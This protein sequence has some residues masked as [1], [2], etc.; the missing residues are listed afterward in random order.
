MKQVLRFLKLDVITVKPYLTWKNLLILLLMPIF[1]VSF[2]DGG[3]SVMFLLMGFGA[4]FASY[5]FAVGEQN[6]I[7]A[8]YATL[9]IKRESVVLGRYLFA[10]SA[11]LFVGLVATAIAAL[12]GIFKEA[13]VDWAQHSADLYIGLAFI[14]FVQAIQLPLFFHLGYAKAKMLGVL[15]FLIIPVVIL[16]YNLFREKLDTFFSS[17]HAWSSVN[18]MLT[19]V[20][21]VAAWLAAMYLSYRISSKAYNKREF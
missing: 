2:T 12:A 7:D 8:L 16:S 18:P 17:I 11:D 9:S 19:S 5:P 14:T 20:L 6:G 3:V 15:P 13:N 10:F 1:F 21:L 4:I